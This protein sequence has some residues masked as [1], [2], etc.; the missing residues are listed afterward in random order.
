MAGSSATST[1][2]CESLIVA[3]HT[4]TH[5]RYGLYEHPPFQRTGWPRR[6]RGSRRDRHAVLR[7][8]PHLLGALER[9]RLEGDAWSTGFPPRWATGASDTVDRGRGDLEVAT[10]IAALH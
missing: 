2:W 3:D 4:T 1:H 6:P 10:D 7:P 9:T 8:K 5:T